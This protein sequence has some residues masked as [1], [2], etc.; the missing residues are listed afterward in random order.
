MAGRGIT[1]WSE[2]WPLFT[3]NAGMWIALP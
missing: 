3:K 1:W 2:A